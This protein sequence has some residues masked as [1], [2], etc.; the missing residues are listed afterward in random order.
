MSTLPQFLRFAAAGTVGF[1]VDAGVLYLTAGVLGWYGARVLS[2][3]AAVTTTWWLNRS[4]TFRAETS[5]QPT[6]PSGMAMEYLRYL[7]SM[8]GGAALN[9]LLYA[10]TVHWTQHPWS[11]LLGVAL[12]SIGGMFAN[13]AAARHLVFRRRTTGPQHPPGT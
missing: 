5:H 1:V 6:Q 7:C 13:Y 2:F 9:Y 12:G 4:I 3:L 8:S 10:A 11:P